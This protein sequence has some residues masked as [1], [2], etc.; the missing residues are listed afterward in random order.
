MV[1]ARGAQQDLRYIVTACCGVV[2]CCVGFGF[3]LVVWWFVVCL[4]GFWWLCVVVVLS[5]FG[6]C[7]PFGW[8][9]F[10][11]WFVGCYRLMLLF[12]C[13]ARSSRYV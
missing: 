7:C 4:L 1:R 12:C 3:V 10:G 13:L 11:C 8:F 9:G 2:W 5:R 6:L